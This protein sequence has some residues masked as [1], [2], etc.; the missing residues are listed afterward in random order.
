MVEAADWLRVRGIGRERFVGYIADY[1]SG[2]GFTVEKTEMA[3]PAATRIDGSLARMNPA[4][5]DGLRK[6]R[7][8]VAPTSGGAAIF[9]EAPSVL[10]TAEF[11]RADR[12]TRELETHLGRAVSTESHGT[13]KVV[14]S[15]VARFP[16]APQA[17]AK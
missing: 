15:P 7:F 11:G 5:P 13:A 17:H 14:R 12:F 1:L 4:V 8:R 3:E 2:L 10:P 6:V 9:W 16:W